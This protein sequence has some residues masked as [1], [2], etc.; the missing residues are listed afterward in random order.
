M[1]DT[2]KKQTNKSVGK[3]IRAL[4]HQHGWSQEDVA[5]RLGISIPA[6]SKIETGVTDINLSRLEQIA[7]IFDVNVVN[8][9]ALD[10]D[11]TDMKPSSLSLAQKKLIDRESEIASLQRKVILLYEEL[12]NKASVAI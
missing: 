10:T 11:E 12:R 2:I 5:N 6:F 3:N 8:I 1:S 7:N 4:R 9:L